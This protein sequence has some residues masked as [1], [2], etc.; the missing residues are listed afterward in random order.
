MSNKR[1]LN[2]GKTE[3]QTSIRKGG[4]YEKNKMKIKKVEQYNGKLP[5]KNK[6]VVNNSTIPDKMKSSK[7]D[8][9]K[10]RQE[11]DQEIGIRQLPKDKIEKP[12]KEL[13]SEYFVRVCNNLFR[14]E[15][16]VLD[17]AERLVRDVQMR[18]E[19]CNDL[20]KEKKIDNDYSADIITAANL[21]NQKIIVDKENEFISKFTG[22]TKT[23]LQI[24]NVKQEL[25]QNQEVK[26]R[27]RLI[28]KSKK[29]SKIEKLMKKLEKE[30]LNKKKNIKNIFKEII[31]ETQSFLPSPREQA[32]IQKKKYEAGQQIGQAAIY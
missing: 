18:R 23:L 25:N 17:Q 4:D 32:D 5:F 20:Q 7:T 3:K 10:F 11:I 16:N 30:K 2:Y 1:L 27:L 26:R 14:N 19:V 29:R 21:A 8:N 13:K 15:D 6:R 31:K 22:P 12:I 24:P 28:R 9:L